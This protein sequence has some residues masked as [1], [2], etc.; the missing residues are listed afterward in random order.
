M[1]QRQNI[2]LA[3]FFVLFSFA[4][5]HMIMKQMGHEIMPKKINCPIAKLANNGY[6]R[7][8]TKFAM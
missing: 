6:F 2:H 5:R 1:Y 4:G 3:I 7:P 8:L